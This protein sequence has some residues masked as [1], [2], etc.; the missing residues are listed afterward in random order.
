MTRKG[1]GTSAHGLRELTGTYV[2]V[3]RTDG[4]TT[5]HEARAPARSTETLRSPVVRSGSCILKISVKLFINTGLVSFVFY[6][7]IIRVH[8]D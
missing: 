7:L 5:T 2:A 1:R 8:S 3:A 6:S 4:R